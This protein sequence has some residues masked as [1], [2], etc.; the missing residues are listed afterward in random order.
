[1]SSILRSAYVISNEWNEYYVNNYIDW[2]TYNIAYD[3]D[4]MKKDKI[5]TNVYKTSLE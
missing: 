5:K 2:N 4:F 3:N 1:M